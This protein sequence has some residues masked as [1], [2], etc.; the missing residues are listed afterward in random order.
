MGDKSTRR[1]NREDAVKLFNKLALQ[2]SKPAIPIRAGV[3]DVRKLYEVLCSE[4]E[5]R[6]ELIRARSLWVDNGGADLDESLLIVEDAAPEDEQEGFPGGE[7]PVSGHRRL[8]TAVAS[9]SFRL[10]AR[11]FMLTF[12]ALAFVA[13]DA[14]FNNFVVWVDERR[15]RFGATYYSACLELSE[16]SDDE[17]RVHLHAYFSWHSAGSHGI[18]H[19]TTDE[20]VYL[21]VRPRVDCNS[22]ARSAWQWLKATQH[23]H[24]YVQVKKE[25]TLYTASNYYAWKGTWVPDALWVVSLWRQHKLS[26]QEYLKLSVKLRDGHDRRKA[27][28]ESVVAAEAALAFESVQSEARKLISLRQLPFKPLPQEVRDWMAQ[29]SEAQERYKMLV[30]Y[31]PSCTGKSKLARHLYGE[32]NT[33]VVD[34]QHAAHPDLKGYVREKHKAI[35]LDEVASPKFIV[36][37][38]KVLQAHIDGALLGQ[39][40][41]QLYTYP[42]FLWRVPLILT[43][44]NWDYSGFNDSDKNWIE[45]NCIAVYIGTKVWQDVADTPSTPPRQ[46]ENKK[47]R[48]WRSPTSR[49]SSNASESNDF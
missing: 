48:V 8:H 4:L 49:Q 19:T 13:D 22:E 43:T 29:Y 2:I 45:T 12:N 28:V 40:A 41:T 26:H 30:L 14:F 46:T 7:Q 3:E 17:A 39:S 21:G 36:G 27:C 38:K 24:F 47:K 25:G 18:D 5:E 31:G 34:V 10:R 9:K 20:W 33:L 1:S 15:K 6:G 42:V 35:L 32:A 11:A 44:N 37:N 23:G 16:H